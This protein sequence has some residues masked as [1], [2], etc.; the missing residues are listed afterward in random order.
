M[1]EQLSN[2]TSANNKLIAKNTIF[3]YIRMIVTLVV[4]LYTSRVILQV[5][6]V[7]DYGIYQAVG[8][9]VAMIGFL[10]G[11][12]SAG[13]SRFLTYELGTGN[14]NKLKLTFSSVFIVHI[15][16]A[17]IVVVLGETVGLW[18]LYHKL[19]MPEGRMM[20]AVWTY[21]LS[22]AAAFFAII[23]VPYNSSIIS[24][25]KMGVY[26]YASIIDAV[27]KLLIVYML[28]LS[29]Y[30]KLIIYSILLFIQSTGMVLF[31]RLYAIKKF[32]ECRIRLIWDKTIIKDVLSY[33]GW[34]IFATTSVALC[35]QGLTV[36]TNMF[37][38]PGVVTARAVANTVNQTANQFVNNFRTAVNP[39][40]VKQ[41]ATGNLAESKNILL[42]STLHSFC[43]FLIIALP[44]LMSPEF[45][46]R[47]WLGQVPEYS[48]PYLQLA[49]C[50]SLFGVFDISFYTG[51][52]AHGRIKE[53]SICSSLFFFIAFIATYLCFRAGLSPITS[54]W[55]L[56][57]AQ[58]I[59]A[60]F[61]K[62]IMLVRIVGYQYMEIYYTLYKCIKVLF[63]SLPLA[64]LSLYL[65]DTLFSNYY[66]QEIM[67]LCISFISATLSVWFIGLNKEVR[68]KIINMLNKKNNI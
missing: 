12:L 1:A 34:N 22:I 57:V 46:L 6:G 36:V 14:T 54:G 31:Y 62:P 10:N 13:T 17:L 66:A 23:Q 9:I 42:N 58:I 3:L 26:A 11:A 2:N 39:Q 63:I 60:V 19:L 18:F 28:L 50:T 44:I 24:H 30:D 8:G 15:L 68:G 25:E 49:I 45:L 29:S 56:L 59:I 64:I 16:L 33:S 5:L 53:N 48:V 52:Y 32:E 21:H 4:S 55:M 47:M 37:F 27:L 7:N 35:A 20:A 51:L 38:M 41:Y 43:L 40:I 61:V 65:K 67:V